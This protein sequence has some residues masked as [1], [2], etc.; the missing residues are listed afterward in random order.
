M[1]GL[2]RARFPDH[3]ERPVATSACATAQL[4]RRPR[5][6]AAVFSMLRMVARASPRIGQILAKFHFFK[7]RENLQRILFDYAEKRPGIANTT[8]NAAC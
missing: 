3:G 5:A 6:P 4:R 1:R 7:L 8:F 2:W